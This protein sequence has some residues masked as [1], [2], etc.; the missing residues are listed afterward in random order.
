MFPTD[1]THAGHPEVRHVLSLYGQ[2]PPVWSSEVLTVAQTLEKADC[3]DGE[4]LAAL[5][6][7]PLYGTTRFARVDLGVQKLTGLFLDTSFS[8]GE[9]TV[10]QAVD[11]LLT[12]PALEARLRFVALLRAMQQVPIM[13]TSR[14]GELAWYHVGHM[15]VYM[16]EALGPKVA[17]KDSLIPP[18]LLYGLVGIAQTA[19]KA[20]A[21][22]DPDLVDDLPGLVEKLQTL[23]GRL[24]VLALPPP[25]LPAMDSDIRRYLRDDELRARLKPR[26]I[27]KL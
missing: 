13:P 20:L 11:R 18:D 5:L 9:I 19:V 2:N 4:T 25:E 17:E 21:A 3:L 22:M 7:A 23:P 27:L 10:G 26:H 16:A 12:S 24:A 1:Y 8:K 14:A 15:I 6:A